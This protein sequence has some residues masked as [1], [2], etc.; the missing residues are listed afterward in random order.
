MTTETMDPAKAEAFAGQMVG[1]LNNAMTALM[2]S[3]AHRT[4]LFDKMATLP[5]SSSEEIAQKTGLNERY[6]REWLGN[7]TTARI[8][9]H[10]PAKGT[11]WLPPEHAASVTRA[12]GPGNLA[13]MSEFFS[14]MGNVED[15]IVE[16]FQKGGGVPYSGFPKFQQLMAQESASIFDAALI[17]VTLPLAGMSDGL[18]KGIDVADIG[19]GQGHAINLMAKAYPNS[20]FTG[21][22]FSDEG[23]AAGKA[24]AKALGLSNAS[25]EQKDV[26]NLGHAGGFALVTAFDAIHDQAQPRKVLKG[27]YDALKPGGVFLM[28][29]IAG[30]STHAGNMEHPLAPLMYGISTFHCM[31]VSLALGGEGLG[32]MWGQQKAM[33]LLEE[34]GF[35]PANIEIKSV[36]GDIMNAYYVCKK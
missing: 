17:D 3:V 15:G 36:E 9:E 18:E 19:C 10:D 33:E 1:I 7:M 24:E 27:I 14:L 8:V 20:R 26:T 31:T 32:T 5:P 2:V 12:A 4:G 35:N 22:D 29:D 11:Y 28:A 30:D 21:F 16:A 23:V 13:A 34:A 25:F 6:V